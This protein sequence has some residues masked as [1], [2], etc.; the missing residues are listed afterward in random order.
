MQGHPVDRGAVRIRKT[1]T[2]WITLLATSWASGT[3]ISLTHIQL[4]S[5][6]A[7]VNVRPLESIV[8][9][10]LTYGKITDKVG[11]QRKVF[12][13]QDRTTLTD[14]ASWLS[15]PFR[16]QECAPPEKFHESEDAG[17]G[18]ILIGRD[19]GQLFLHDNVLYSVPDRS[20]HYQIQAQLE[21]KKT[22]SQISIER[23]TWSYRVVEKTSCPSELYTR[24]S[25]CRDEFTSGSGSTYL[26]RGRFEKLKHPNIRRVDYQFL[27]TYDHWWLR[28]NH[29]PRR[30]EQTF[31]TYYSYQPVGC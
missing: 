22:S 5:D 27:P 19:Y 13:L 29:G 24:Y 3:K 10:L 1:A 31:D 2:L 30:A 12:I 9:Q 18:S 26:Y 21:D 14:N 8:V 15:K 17:L 20:F 11:Q 28:A 4:R 16:Y 7:E 25:A 23:R 6:L